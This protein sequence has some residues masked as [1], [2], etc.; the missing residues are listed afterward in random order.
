MCWKRTVLLAFRS[1]CFTLSRLYCL[2]SLPV[3][4]VGKDVIFDCI[5][6][7]SLLFIYQKTTAE[8]G[9]PKFLTSNSPMPP[10]VW[11]FLALTKLGVYK[12][13]TGL[14]FLT[15][16]GLHAQQPVIK[17]RVDF[18]RTLHFQSWPWTNLVCMKRPPGW[19]FFIW[20]RLHAQ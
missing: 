2:C 5:G 17:W 10:W 8:T 11:Y 12:K 7:W 20:T 15:W 9:F 4:R 18:I 13:S 6:A 16:N 14:I 1:C 3:W 19:F